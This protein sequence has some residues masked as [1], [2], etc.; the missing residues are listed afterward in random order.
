MSLENLHQTN[1]LLSYLQ[2]IYQENSV[3]TIKF[4]NCRY[5]SLPYIIQTAPISEIGGC[6]VDR[7]RI[8]QL[9]VFGIQPDNVRH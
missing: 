8:P 6:H 9:G 1:G 3:A 4:M 2:Y 5:F 7:S